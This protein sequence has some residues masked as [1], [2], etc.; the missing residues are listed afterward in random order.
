MCL[1]HSYLRSTCYV[2]DTVLYRLCECLLPGTQKKISQ[3]I[4]GLN[5][6]YLEPTHTNELLCR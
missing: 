6:I 4:V 5:L 1:F 2:P 3:I